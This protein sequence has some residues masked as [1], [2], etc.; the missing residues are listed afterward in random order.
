MDEDFGFGIFIGSQVGAWVI[1]LAVAILWPSGNKT[2]TMDCLSDK[3]NICRTI[4]TYTTPY[5]E[6]K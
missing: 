1:I 2:V 4:T 5:K 3:P 6:E